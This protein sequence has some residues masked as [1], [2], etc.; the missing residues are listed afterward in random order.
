MHLNVHDLAVY[1]IFLP[2][3]KIQAFLRQIIGRKKKDQ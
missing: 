2:K 1:L 3:D